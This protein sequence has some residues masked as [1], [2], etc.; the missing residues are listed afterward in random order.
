MHV[1]KAEWLVVIIKLNLDGKQ[2]LDLELLYKGNVRIFMGN[3]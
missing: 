3:K 1:N 2:R